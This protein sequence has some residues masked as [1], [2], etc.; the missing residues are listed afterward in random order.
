MDEEKRKVKVEKWHRDPIGGVIFGLG[1]ILCGIIWFLLESGLIFIEKLEEL[2]WAY[3]LLGI[4]LLLVLEVIIRILF[5]KY[6]RGI[7][8]KLILSFIL[9]AIGGSNILEIE[10]WWPLVLILVGFLIIVRALE[11]GF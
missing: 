3:L 5:P 9:I 1:V 7:F 4:G 2:W 10:T 8:G 11:R 6:R